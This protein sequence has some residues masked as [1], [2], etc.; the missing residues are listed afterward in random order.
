MNT[1]IPVAILAHMKP[2]TLANLIEACREIEEI[3]KRV[4]PKRLKRKAKEGGGRVKKKRR[5]EGEPKFTDQ[6]VKQETCYDIDLETCHEADCSTDSDDD[7]DDDDTTMRD[8]DDSEG[9]GDTKGGMKDDTQSHQSAPG[10]FESTIDPTLLSYDYESSSAATSSSATSASDAMANNTILL[11]GTAGSHMAAT[12]TSIESPTAPALIHSSLGTDVVLRAAAVSGVA[13]LNTSPV[14]STARSPTTN[15]ET[16]NPSQGRPPT[17]PISDTMSGI[18]LNKD[19][20]FVCG[21]E[22]KCKLAYKSRASVYR[23]WV[24]RHNVAPPLKCSQCSAR[25]WALAQ[26]AWHERRCEGGG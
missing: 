10:D 4:Y 2:Q 7:D 15:S 26:L 17:S 13:V 12:G 14:P 18:A 20:Q 23:H 6:S 3:R 22:G 11:A 24:S 1:N 25:F 19:G 8:V 5:V 16:S 9:D 21:F